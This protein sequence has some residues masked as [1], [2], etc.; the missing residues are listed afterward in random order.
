MSQL[1][2]KRR[3]GIIDGDMVLDTG[4]F[5]RT[6]GRINTYLFEIGKNPGLGAFVE[7]SEFEGSLVLSFEGD[8][9][10]DFSL[11]VGFSEGELE[12]RLITDKHRDNP[13]IKFQSE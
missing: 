9:Q 8:E 13:P 12:C 1:E 4:N 7:I 5:F 3:A 6:N 10:G 11:W 2:D